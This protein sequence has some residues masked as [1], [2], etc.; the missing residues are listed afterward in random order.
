MNNFRFTNQEKY[1]LLKCFILNNQNP[2]RARIEYNNLY[3][4][5]RQSGLSS[6]RRLVR[7]LKEYG[8][9]TKP[10]K[11]RHKKAPK[12]KKTQFC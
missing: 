6:F 1:D 12:I 2:T 5:R 8:S 7:N 9:F 10:V 3:P 4:E 11:K